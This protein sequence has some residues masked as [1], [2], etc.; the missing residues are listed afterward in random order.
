MKTS[1]LK[2]ELTTSEAKDMI[3]ITEKEARTIRSLV[4]SL[5]NQLSALDQVLDSIGVESWVS[6]D[7]PRTLANYKF[8]IKNED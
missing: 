3:V 2:T 7:H 1:L 4:T 6:S 5:S 8:T